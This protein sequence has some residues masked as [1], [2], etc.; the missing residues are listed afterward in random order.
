MSQSQKYDLDLRIIA[1]TSGREGN[2]VREQSLQRSSKFAAKMWL[3]EI[4]KR[5]R[6]LRFPCA[7]VKGE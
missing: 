1:R 5:V 2:L 6:E 3:E 4:G 7:V